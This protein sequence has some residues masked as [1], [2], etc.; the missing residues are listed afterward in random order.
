MN[1]SARSEMLQESACATGLRRSGDTSLCAH[2]GPAREPC[3]LKPPA[4]KIIRSQRRDFPHYRDSVDER[5]APR[6]EP[7][8]NLKFGTEQ[9]ELLC[10]NVQTGFIKGSL[11]FGECQS[12]LPDGSDVGQC[13]LS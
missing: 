1:G 11:R 8:P 12:R 10:L 2:R 13:T 9:E 6:R 5:N 3:V 4:Q 7:V